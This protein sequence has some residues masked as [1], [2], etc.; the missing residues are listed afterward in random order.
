MEGNDTRDNSSDV[1]LRLRCERKVM[2]VPMKDVVDC[3]AHEKRESGFGS[4]I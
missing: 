2:I 4:D 3:L 1:I